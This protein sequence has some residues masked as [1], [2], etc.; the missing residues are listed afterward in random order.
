MLDV[1]QAIVEVGNVYRALTGRPIEAGRAELP[2]EIDPRAHI[3]GRYRQLKSILDGADKAPAAAPPVAPPWT[4]ALEVIEQEHALRFELELPGVHRDHIALAVI[5]DALVV[6][7]QRG[8]AP[9]GKGTVRHS[10]RQAGPFTRVIPLPSQ[11]RRDA[12]S[13]SLRDG[14]LSIAV[15]TDGPTAGPQIIEIR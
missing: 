12:I 4:P 1:E 2:P 15:P 10:E 13:A 7:G 3:E 11:A 8:G 6:R 14:V 5:G 9:P